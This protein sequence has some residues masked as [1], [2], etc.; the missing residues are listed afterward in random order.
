MKRDLATEPRP[1]PHPAPAPCPRRRQAGQH[2]AVGPALAA[3]R[4]RVRRARRHRRRHVSALS[5]LAWGPG[6]AGAA[7]CTAPKPPTP[8][9][10]ANNLPPCFNEIVDFP[11]RSCRAHANMITSIETSRHLVVS[12]STDKSVA[13]WD[14]RWAVGGSGGGGRCALALRSRGGVERT[15]PPPWRASAGTVG[16]GHS[17]GRAF[18][19]ARF[20]PAS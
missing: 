9:R 18:M 8:E 7:A 14:V 4:G 11:F 17:R 19:G 2:A 10:T 5:R 15:R 16:T 20:G 3:A 13:L 1:S 6:R 12:G